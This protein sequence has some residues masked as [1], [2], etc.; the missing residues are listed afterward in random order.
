VKE[1]TTMECKHPEAFVSI[2]NGHRVCGLCGA[3][4][5]EPVAAAEPAEKKPAAKAEPKKGGKAYA[6]K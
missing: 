6:R 4:V 3:I 5:P 2:K 1:E